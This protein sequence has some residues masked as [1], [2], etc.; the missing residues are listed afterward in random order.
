MDT[1]ITFLIHGWWWASSNRTNRATATAFSGNSSSQFGGYRNAFSIKLPSRRIFSWSVFVAEAEA[2]QNHKIKIGSQ[3]SLALSFDVDVIFRI[4]R[5]YTHSLTHPHSPIAFDAIVRR[6]RGTWS[7]N[8]VRERKRKAR[9]CCV[10]LPSPQMLTR[11]NFNI[12]C[13]TKLVS[14]YDCMALCHKQS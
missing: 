2:T 5:R 6:R 9:V 4:Y 3:S 1:A 8:S 14:V 11:L 10:V 7:H 12:I 13:A